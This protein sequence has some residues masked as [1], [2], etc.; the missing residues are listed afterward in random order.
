MSEQDAR[1]GA[2]IEIEGVLGGELRVERLSVL[3]GPSAKP[4]KTRWR[5][6]GLSLVR[7]EGGS[8]A[9]DAS[10]M[11]SRA[12]VPPRTIRA[13]W[14]RAR[15]E[16]ELI[17]RD[18]LD[19]EARVVE[20]R[21]AHVTAG[22]RVRVRGV[23]TEVRAVEAGAGA[24]FRGAAR[25]DVAALKV[26]HVAHG[27]DPARALA[28][29]LEGYVP[30]APAE[31]SARGY[32]PWLFLGC[33]VVCAALALSTRSSPQWLAQW[34]SMAASFAATAGAMLADRGLLLAKQW[35]HSAHEPRDVRVSSELSAGFFFAIVAAVG[36]GLMLA[37]DAVA[38]RSAT[39]HASMAL[40][41]TVALSLGSLLYGWTS[42]RVARTRVAQLLSAQSPTAA[43]AGVIEGII[44]DPTPVESAL[45]PAGIVAIT[46]EEVVSCSDPN[47]VAHSTL[48]DDGFVLRGRAGDLAI[49]PDGTSWASTLYSAESRGEQRGRPLIVHTVVV[50]VGAPAIAWGRLRHGEG[51]AALVGE[52]GAAPV[53]LVCAR[54][55]QPLAVLRALRTKLR[56]GL[57]LSLL[58]LLSTLAVIATQWSAIP[59]MPGG[60]G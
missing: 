56:A 16:C 46:E 55:E 49:D 58:S 27:A 41:W 32:A 59:P 39:S 53:L 8:V 4:R 35:K 28:L 26:T 13:A 23:V 51:G 37:L 21:I 52:G 12:V 20:L 15:S 57:A 3:H 31:P 5:R 24:A 34:A 7:D 6:H 22:Q 60:E 10:E 14:G 29:A 36:V 47:I 48:T 19:D 40:L 2:V 17:A 18:E 50:P 11:E 33:A 30:P 42:S 38:S 54:D 43:T 44:V 1:V 45:G 9:L 25:L